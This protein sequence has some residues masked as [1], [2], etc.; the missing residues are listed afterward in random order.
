MLLRTYS[1]LTGAALLA[2][3]IVCLIVIAW[4]VVFAVGAS[5]EASTHQL[6]EVA[7]ATNGTQRTVS[8]P[9][10]TGVQKTLDEAAKAITSPFASVASSSSS[11]WLIHGVDTMLALL[12]YGIGFGFLVRV[13]RVRV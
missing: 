2:S 5:K 7:T 1:S 11:A 3:R 13:L 8:E 12:I 10:A 9:P 4:F 6:N